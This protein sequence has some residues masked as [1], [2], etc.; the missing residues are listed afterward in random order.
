M[1]A[2]R[3][4][5]AAEIDAEKISNII[6]LVVFLTLLLVILFDDGARSAT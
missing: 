5:R 4:L 6:R 3:L 1:E 2:N